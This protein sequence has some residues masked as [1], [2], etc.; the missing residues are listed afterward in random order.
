MVF[1][2]EGI[3]SP[4]HIQMSTIPL[5]NDN[6]DLIAEAVTGSG[7]TLAYL[8]PSFERIDVGLKDLHTIVLVP[9]HELAVQINNVIKKS[10]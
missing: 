7:K 3:N 1:K 4:T 2:K 8:L 5:I 10:C 9:T 6:K